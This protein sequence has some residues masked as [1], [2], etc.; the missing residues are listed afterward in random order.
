M[1]GAIDVVSTPGVGSV[2]TLRL[3]AAAPA[4]AALA[5]RRVRELGAVA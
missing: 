4:S 5:P 1:E 3:R 2:F